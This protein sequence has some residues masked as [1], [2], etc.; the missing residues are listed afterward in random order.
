[1]PRRGFPGGGEQLWAGSTQGRTSEALATPS[2]WILL[3][4]IFTLQCVHRCVGFG[5]GPERREAKVA[6]QNVLSR[7]HQDPEERSLLFRAHPDGC[8]C[9]LLALAL[10][11][12]CAHT[13]G[14][15][16]RTC[17]VACRA[18]Q[19]NWLFPRSCSRFFLVSVVLGE[20]PGNGDEG[21]VIWFC[22]LMSI[23]SFPSGPNLAAKRDL[24]CLQKTLTTSVLCSPEKGKFNELL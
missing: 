1:M 2:S 21:Q 11:P 16:P 4:R 3:L 22:P 19:T 24:P 9:G 5:E 12:A 8:V 10:A 15:S 18:L 7:S 20:S 23:S 14:L 17:V 6:V 13:A